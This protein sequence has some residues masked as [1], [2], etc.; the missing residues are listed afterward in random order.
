[1][2]LLKT[3]EVKTRISGGRR[4]KRVEIGEKLL[5]E[6][7]INV[8][9]IVSVYVSEGKITIV[10]TNI[11]CPMCGEAVKSVNHECKEVVQK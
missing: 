8:G 4:Y 6:A 1:M 11:T 7:N 5:D 2:R 3:L 9:D 10:K